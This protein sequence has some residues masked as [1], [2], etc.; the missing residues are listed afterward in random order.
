MRQPTERYVEVARLFRE[1]A[2][3]EGT[4]LAVEPATTEDLAAAEAALGCRFPESYHWF[5]LEFGW[6]SN[7]PVNIYTVRN[8]V[9]ESAWKI[10]GINLEERRDAQPALPAHLIAFSDSG[11]GDFCCFDTSAF[12][13]GECP[14]V[15]WDHVQDE[16]QTPEEAG[17]SFLDWLEA[18]L[19]ERAAEEKGSLL[20]TLGHVH[21][22]W[23]RE[24]L[25][26]K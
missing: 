16:D 4:T 9:E 7:G 5:Q 10:V 22:T 17:P 8:V 23:L 25:K 1:S 24:W 15:W 14:I 19:Q 3:A 18:E 6:V 21:Q 11:G 2:H 13:D 12:K 26:K 20:D